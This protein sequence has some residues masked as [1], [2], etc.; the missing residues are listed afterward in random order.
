MTAERRNPY[1][2]LG[3]PYGSTK[4]EAA[5]AFAKATRRIRNTDDAPY[6]IE[7][8]NWALHQIEQVHDDPESAVAIFRVPA[9]PSVYE[10]DGPGILQPPPLP[11]ER[12]TPPTDPEIPAGIADSAAAEIL[13][14]LMQDHGRDLRPEP[15][16]DIEREEH[17]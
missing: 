9:N 2:I 5:A 7:D 10:L 15:P 3:L 8:L 11:M 6:D 1:L 16:F 17:D 4:S 12:R 13:R 14:T